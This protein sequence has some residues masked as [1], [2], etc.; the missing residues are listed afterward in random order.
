MA[1]REV[2][3]VLLS[4]HGEAA[5]D[6]ALDDAV[7]DDGRHVAERRLCREVHDRILDA[8]DAEI[9][10]RDEAIELAPDVHRVCLH[11]EVRQVLDGH[12]DVEADAPRERH[13]HVAGA[14]RAHDDRLLRVVDHDVALAR[15]EPPD[16]RRS[17]LRQLQRDA[18]LQHLRADLR[19]AEARE[20]PPAKLGA[21]VDGAARARA[22]DAGNRE[23]EDDQEE[24]GSTHAGRSDLAHGS[25]PTPHV[26]SAELSV[27]TSRRRHRRSGIR[28]R[29]SWRR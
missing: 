23:R 10:R 22:A 18:A 6:L 28:R 13:H 2:V 26:T 25:E 7:A 8:E 29:R 19:G 4:D 12:P 21:R 11:A 9:G 24:E 27:H 5:A 20:E 16:A 3:T 15:E 14:R 1:D 17:E